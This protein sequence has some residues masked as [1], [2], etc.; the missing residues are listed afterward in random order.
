MVSRIDSR[1]NPAEARNIWPKLG[2]QTPDSACIHRGS[3]GSFARELPLHCFSITSFAPFKRVS[4]VTRRVTRCKRIE[5]RSNL[6]PDA[7]WPSS[8]DPSLTLVYPTLVCQDIGWVTPK[9]KF[10][11]CVVDPTSLISYHSIWWTVVC[12][13]IY[14]YVHL[15]NVDAAYDDD[16]LIH[17]F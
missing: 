11:P 3:M 13:Y 16:S 2:Q 4:L 17:L 12:T 1:C 9:W 15:K 14:I 6:D 7:R 10:H 8:A 5:T